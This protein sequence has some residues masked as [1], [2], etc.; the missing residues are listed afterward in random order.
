MKD[1][2][3]IKSFF[4]ILFILAIFFWIINKRLSNIEKMRCDV[5]RWEVCAELMGK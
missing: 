4:I 5:W 3:T 1:K 2:N